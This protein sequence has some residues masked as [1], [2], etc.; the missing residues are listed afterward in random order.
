[1]GSIHE[2]ESARRECGELERASA[3]GAFAGGVVV[4]AAAAWGV[5]EVAGGLGVA[6]VVYGI[7]EGRRAKAKRADRS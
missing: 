2:A 5:L 1:M 6:P 7:L 3:L 4:G